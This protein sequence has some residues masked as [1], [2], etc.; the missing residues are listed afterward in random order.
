MRSSES[1]STRSMA[2]NSEE[3]FTTGIAV[4]RA[5]VW[6]LDGAAFDEGGGASAIAGG[7][8]GGAEGISAGFAFSAPRLIERFTM[9]LRSV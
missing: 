9:A 3:G 6:G 8:D 1:F 2:S 4:T 5:G 7:A